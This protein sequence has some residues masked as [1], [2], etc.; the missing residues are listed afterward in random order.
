[1]VTY[2]QLKDANPA[3]FHQS[4]AA[5]K[6]WADTAL[7]HAGYLNDRVGQH[8]TEPHWGGLTSEL[9][10]GRVAD[11]HVDLSA[12]ASQLKT[13]ETV[14]IQAGQDFEEA[15]NDLVTATNEATQAGFNVSDSGD[16]T[17][18]ATLTKDKKPDEVTTINN[19]ASTLQTRITAAVYR[20]TRVDAGV[21]KALNALDPSKAGG[22]N[23]ANGGGSGGSGG[24]HGGAGWNGDY[25][26]SGAPPMQRPSGQVADWINQAIQILRQQGINLSPQD[27]GYIATIIQYESGGNPNSINLWDSNAAAGHPSKGLMQT[28]DPTFNSYALPGHTSVYNPVDNIIAGTRY[29]LHRYGS[30][31]N[32]PGIRNI[33][34]HSG[35]YVGY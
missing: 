10:R 2:R 5:W 3:M 9:A 35:G 20:A 11:A 24:G 6:D 32:V 30:L 33:L 28:I 29:A 19:H 31:S 8:I 15:Q 13:V 27:A 25:G 4:A 34:H 23:G 18:P 7:Q 12:S 14:L 26:S 16:V 21:T 17:V 22:R 1:M